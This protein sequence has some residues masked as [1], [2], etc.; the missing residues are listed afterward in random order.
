MKNPNQAV[1]SGPVAT[2]FEPS[3]NQRL[4]DQIKMDLVDRPTACARTYMTIRD[5]ANDEVDTSY[6][7]VRRRGKY[8]D[9]WSCSDCDPGLVWGGAFHTH[10]EAVI[11]ASAWAENAQEDG[12]AYLDHLKDEE[13]E[14]R[15][16]EASTTKLEGPFT[17][18]DNTDYREGWDLDDADDVF[19][20]CNSSPDF[21]DPK[22]WGN[23]YECY[24]TDADG[25]LCW[26]ARSHR[27][28]MFIYSLDDPW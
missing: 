22:S 1:T 24:L 18:F 20:F 2:E 25:T 4:K 16:A 10:A 12:D 19:N 9:V 17:Y 11:H 8:F 5:E 6:F 23:L 14:I 26:V 21:F 7:A 15:K 13:W 28:E 27:G 3:L